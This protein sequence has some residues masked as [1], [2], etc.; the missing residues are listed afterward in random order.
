MADAYR[1]LVRVGLES[2]GTIAVS[3]EMGVEI[4]RLA[5][6]E[7][8]SYADEVRHLLRLAIKVKQKKAAR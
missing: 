5:E 2:K 4:E 6:A 8:R 1:H 7:D 3:S